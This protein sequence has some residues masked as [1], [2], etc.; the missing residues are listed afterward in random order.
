MWL[1]GRGRRAE[2]EEAV[3]AAMRL[4]RCEERFPK[5]D[6]EELRAAL[7]EEEAAKEEV[8]HVAERKLGIMKIGENLNS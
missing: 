5:E 3:E 6:I 2:A 7:K 4:N 8:R 1:L